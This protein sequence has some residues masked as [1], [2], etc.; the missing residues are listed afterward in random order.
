M[1]KRRVDT[2][3][4]SAAGPL[5]NQSVERA[6]AILEAFGGERRTLNVVEMATATGMTKSS[7]LRALTPMTI[8]SPEQ[9]LARVAAAR[10]AGYAWCDQECYRG[11]PT[12]GAPILG[13]E[14]RPIAAVNISGPTNRWTLDGLRSK[15]SSVLI[16]TARAASSGL[17]ARLRA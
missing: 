13:D 8:T 12:I 16:E 4:V 9:V 11:D 17:A 14:S 2:V 6:L 7:A 3:Q 15:L 10:K 5:F 1:S